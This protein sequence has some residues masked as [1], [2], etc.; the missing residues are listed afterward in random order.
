[1]TYRANS[2]TQ[3]KLNAAFGF[4]VD[5][6]SASTFEAHGERRTRYTVKRPNGAKLYHAMMLANGS[7][8]A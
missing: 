8:I 7:V 2:K 1:M 6:V 4:A 5:V 3:S